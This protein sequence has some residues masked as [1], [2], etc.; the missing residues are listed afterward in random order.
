M[1]GCIYIYIERYI[2]KQASGVQI[3]YILE[4]PALLATNF[5]NAHTYIY[6]VCTLLLCSSQVGCD[7]QHK[8]KQRKHHAATRQKQQ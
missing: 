4:M 7:M 3:E 5:V 6:Y 1:A 8:S 2:G